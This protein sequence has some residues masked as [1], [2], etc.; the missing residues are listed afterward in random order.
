[1]TSTNRKINHIIGLEESILSKYHLSLL[2]QHNPCQITNGR[3]RTKDLIFY[4]NTKDPKQPKQSWEK[5]RAGEIRFLD[6][7]YTIKLQSSWTVWKGKKIWRWDELPSWVG[8][9]Y[10]TGKSGAIAQEVMKRLSQSGNNAQRWM[11]LVVKVKSDA[12]KNNNA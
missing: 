11:C 7:D 3:S 8:A 10:A 9:L 2:I 4:G 12:I 5:N 6:S 1:M